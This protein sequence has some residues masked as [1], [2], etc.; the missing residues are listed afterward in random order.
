M[1]YSYQDLI[2]CMPL[3][4]IF[5]VQKIICPSLISAV[6][7]VFSFLI[8]PHVWGNGLPFLAAFTARNQLF[9]CLLRSQEEEN[10]GCGY[11]LIN[12]MIQ[13]YVN[14][15]Q[16]LAQQLILEALYWLINLAAGKKRLSSAISLAESKREHSWM[17]W[18]KTCWQCFL[19]VTP[20]ILANILNNALLTWCAQLLLLGLKEV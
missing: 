12:I 3:I 18:K 6:L 10:T 7:L 15:F 14:K 13:K 9:L 20:L 4:S 11:S 16:W 1:K 17:E 19:S 8:F 2:F 5:S